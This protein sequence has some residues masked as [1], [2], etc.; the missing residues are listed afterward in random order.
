L[1]HH[2]GGESDFQERQICPKPGKV[3]LRELRC[4]PF[5]VL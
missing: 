5:N 1:R 4:A 3:L 2:N